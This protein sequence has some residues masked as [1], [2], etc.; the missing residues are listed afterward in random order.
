MT[1]PSGT[2]APSRCTKYFQAPGPASVSI[3]CAIGAGEPGEYA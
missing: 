2:G 3:A 1:S